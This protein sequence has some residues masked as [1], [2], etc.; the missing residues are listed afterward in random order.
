MAPF[1][2][3][4]AASVAITLFLKLRF[5]AYLPS[6]NL[7]TTSFEIFAVETVAWLVWRCLLY[8][9]LF[10]PLRTLPG[11]SVYSH[12]PFFRENPSLAVTRV[13]HSSWASLRT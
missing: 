4:L 6:Q 3:F 9:K 1:K 10:S 13:A 8:P 2:S 5:E 11:P 12:P 7:L